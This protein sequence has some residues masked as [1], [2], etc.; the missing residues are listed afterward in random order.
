LTRRWA[1]QNPAKERRQN[2][3][4]KSQDSHEMPVLSD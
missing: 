1:V 2:E 3:I 4:E